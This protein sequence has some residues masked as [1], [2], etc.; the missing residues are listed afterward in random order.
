MSDLR[1]EHLSVRYGER[2]AVD[3]VDLH[4]AAGEIVAVLGPSGCGK[5]SLLR[6]VAGLERPAGGRILMDGVDLSGVPTHR[7]GIGLMFQDHA[8]FSHLDVAGNV[9]FG[10]RMRRVPRTDADRRVAGMLALVGLADR[11]GARIDQLSGGEQQRVAL[12]RTLAPSPD[13]V[14]LDEPLGSLDRALRRELLATLAE[15]FAATRATVLYVTH[16]HGEAFRLAG[17]I[18]IMRGGRLDQVGSAAELAE[19]PANPWI[20]GFLRD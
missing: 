2:L 3:G 15:A 6:A 1:L 14:L 17:R 20:A 4:V 5:T 11:S 7:R 18:A 13:V 9:R 19:R 10:L 16:D 12:A 8:L